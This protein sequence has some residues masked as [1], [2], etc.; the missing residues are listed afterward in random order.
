[1]PFLI[2]IAILGF[3]YFKEWQSKKK[4]QIHIF[5]KIVFCSILVLVN[6]LVFSVFFYT[7]GMVRENVEDNSLS[8]RLR[9]ADRT[10]ENGNFTE[11][12]SILWVYDDYE[13]DFEPYW[14]KARMYS[15]GYYYK[16]YE[17]AAQKC[18][19]NEEFA[20]Q[21]SLYRER[22]E[23]ICENPEFEEN[24]YLADYFREKYIGQE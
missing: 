18:E 13:E 22:L 12:V 11:L 16:I 3:L 24:R 6:I 10:V 8:N 19:D 20:G 4:G 7:L 17:M 21:A 2:F 5:R 1:M 14:E 23:K 15:N 9:S